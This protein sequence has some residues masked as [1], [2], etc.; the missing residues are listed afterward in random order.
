[1]P[2]YISEFQYYG[3]ATQEFIEVALPAGT[4]PSGYTVEIYDA[5]GNLIFGFPLAAPTETAGG[6]DVYV[7]DASTP[8]FDNS[9]SDPTGNFYPDDAVALVDGQ[10]NVEQFLSYWDNTVTA[11]GGAASGMTSRDVGTASA[12]Q[13]LQSDDQGQTYYTQDTP[14]P[15]TIPAC[16]AAG[17]LIATPSGPCPVEQLAVGDCVLG[18]HGKAQMVRWVWSGQQP[19]DGVSADHKPVL[20]RAGALGANLPE[21]DLVVSGQHR[22]VVGGMGQCEGGFH[23]PAFVPAKALT[24]LRGVRFMAGKRSII[25]HH[26]LCDRH[27]VIFANG[28]ASESLLL[29]PAILHQMDRTHLAALSVALNR[30]VTRRTREKAALPCLTAGAARRALERSTKAG[31]QCAVWQSQSGQSIWN[32]MVSGGP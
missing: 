2:G 1:M 12:G 23:A 18:Q 14:N 9:D 22:I 3:D 17:S 19:L 21:Q 4:D 26:F 29:G 7:V 31:T 25:W 11:N 24:G 15:G 8:G 27:S 10:G 32:T 5:S 20:I 13:S 16:Y 30:R 28:L 6:Y